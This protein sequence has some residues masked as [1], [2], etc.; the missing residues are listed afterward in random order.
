M[1][2]V[3][4]LSG[5]QIQLH[6]SEKRWK[7]NDVRDIVEVQADGDELNAII[8]HCPYLRAKQ[9]G[10][11]EVVKEHVYTDDGQHIGKVGSSV[12]FIPRPTQRWFGTDAQ[13][14]MSWW[15]AL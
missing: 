2:Y 9:T 3:T 14:A 11:H 6:V 13:H 7:Y 5:R 10:K 12:V 1:L 15:P 8:N 4:F